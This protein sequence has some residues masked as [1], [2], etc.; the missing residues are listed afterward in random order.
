MKLVQILLPT[1]DNRGHKFKNIIFGRIRKELVSRFGGLTA[2]SRSPARGV[3]KSGDSTKLDD[4]VV[5]EVMTEEFKRNW[6][7]K[8]RRKLE[9]WLRQD[10]IVMRVQDINII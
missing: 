6:W 3:W 2:Y 10:E 7:K 4:I 8:Y 5:V 1:R 9:R